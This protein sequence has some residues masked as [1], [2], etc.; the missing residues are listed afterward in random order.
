MKIKYLLFILTAVILS[1]CSEEWFETSA[2]DQ[3]PAE[4]AF[5]TTKDGRNLLNG[6]FSNFQDESMYGADFI[7]Y[8][9]VKGTDVRTSSVGKRTENMYTFQETTD[10][11]TSTLWSWSYNS[12][13]NVN[14]MIAAE[15]DMKSDGSAQDDAY[16]SYLMANA[17][18]VRALVHFE[19]VRFYGKMPAN[20]NPSTDL[21]IVVLTE[22]IASDAKLPRNT[23]AETYAQIFKDLDYALSIYPASFTAPFGWFDDW[24]IKALY[25]RASLYYGNDA[26]ALMYSEDIITNGPFAL[27][28]AASYVSSWTTDATSES[29]LTLV[30]TADDNPSREGIS[31]LWSPDGYTAMMVTADAVT[32]LQSDANDIRQDLIAVNPNYG[33]E[34]YLLKF[35]DDFSNNIDLIRLSEM[36]LTAAEA[37]FKTSD[38]TK[39]DGYI[40]D[41]YRVRTDDATAVVAGVTLDRILLERRKE[42]I[43][44]GHRFFDLMRNGLPLVRTGADHFLTAPLNVLPTDYRVI[45]PI[46][47]YELD[48]NPNIVQNGEY[49]N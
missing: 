5:N 20:G 22:P 10:A 23:V 40:Q 9:A 12:I 15:A 47:R 3:L 35:P 27:I 29:I 7:N 32:L 36:Y 26:D 33:I 49:L 39:A 18:A 16:K 6:V 21:G 11:S 48:V 13:M 37:A 1:S 25:A 42:L 17:Y 44:E 31:Y 38:F 8:A 4:Q 46:P 24:A 28:P 43:G 45:Q 41:I 34:G 30:N 2:S 19:L 14:Y